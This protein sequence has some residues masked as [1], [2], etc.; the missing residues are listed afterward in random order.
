[1][2]CIVFFFFF[3][4][5]KTAYEI[6]PSLVGSEMCI[7]DSFKAVSHETHLQI[8]HDQLHT[9]GLKQNEQ[10]LPKSDTSTPNKGNKYH[11][12]VRTPMR[13]KSS[14]SSKNN[15]Y[16]S[17]IKTEPSQN[18]QTYYQTSRTR[19]YNCNTTSNLENDNSEII[20]TKSRSIIKASS[21]IQS[22]SNNQ[23]DKSYVRESP[24]N[25][26]IKNCATAIGI[27][28]GNNASASKKKNG[29]DDN[30]SLNEINDNLNNSSGN[31]NNN[32]NMNDEFVQYDIKPVNCSPNKLNLL[33]INNKTSSLT[34][35]Y[36]QKQ[37]TE[38]G[39]SRTNRNV[40]SLTEQKPSTA[41]Q[42]GGGQTGEVYFSTQRVQTS[43]GNRQA[44]KKQQLKINYSE[45]C[46]GVDSEIVKKR[47]FRAQNH[48]VNLS[49]LQSHNKMASNQ[50]AVP[51]RTLFS[52][53]KEQV[54]ETCKSRMQT[55]PE[56]VVCDKIYSF[57][58]LN[59]DHH[60]IQQQQQQ[61]QQQQNQFKQQQQQQQQQQGNQF[62]QTNFENNCF[63]QGQ[64][65]VY[66]NSQQ[67]EEKD[68]PMQNSNMFLTP[69]KQKD[70]KQLTNQMV[71]DNF[72][73]AIEQEINNNF[74]T[75]QQ[76]NQMQIVN[77]EQNPNYSN[78]NRSNGQNG[79][80]FTNSEAKKNTVQ[81][82]ILQTSK[83][84]SSIQVQQQIQKQLMK[85]FHTL[86]SHKLFPGNFALIKS[87]KY[88]KLKRDVNGLLNYVDNNEELKQKL[89][90]G[91]D[92]NILKMDKIMD[93][94]IGKK[95]GTLVIINHMGKPI[96]YNATN[97]FLK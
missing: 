38:S 36:T 15:K 80:S 54:M 67:E 14:P 11:K 51:F 37:K 16:S 62:T 56:Q 65:R 39:D 79:L 52:K 88:D 74:F 28:G 58:Q 85:D 93:N 43:S 89:Q 44:Q 18:S 59:C 69:E 24:N 78:L 34:K 27:S 25:S 91:C 70:F 49:R 81:P 63:S 86:G 26:Q 73:Q 94:L 55:A 35:Y 40:R 22:V 83:Y 30:S 3:F 68:Y 84:F 82:Q 6:M 76:Q 13:D 61:A 20:N 77:C 87:E 96:K 17:F 71:D 53:V 92:K 5:Q 75:Q 23:E 19:F 60:P 64:Q 12:T 90:S 1:M 7:R 95:N 4:K 48:F 45:Q 72:D 31:N 50:G 66:P 21:H 97:L 57:E 33:T 2:V 8:E 32:G 9:Q 47:M 10:Q 29:N 41:H 46:Q 42:Q